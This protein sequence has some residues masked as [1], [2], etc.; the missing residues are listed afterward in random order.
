MTSDDV[1]GTTASTRSYYSL[2]V[3]LTWLA[4]CFTLC[5]LFSVI[6]FVSLLNKNILP[7]ELGP[8]T[9]PY[10][11]VPRHYDVQLQFNTEYNQ[12][13]T[14]FH[15][16][17]ALLFSSRHV[18]QRLFI[19]RG[20]YLRITDFSLIAVDQSNEKRSIKK[21]TYNAA[22]EIQTF[23]LS[24]DTA[25]DELYLF[26]MKFTGKMTVE[27][28]PKEFTYTSNNGEQRYGVWFATLQRNS[29]GLRYLFPCMD[30]NEFPAE[31]NITI[32]RKVSLR[33][34]SNFIAKRTLQSDANFMI[35]YFPPIT[36]LS[37]YQFALVLCD[38]QYRRENHN[39]TT[40]SVYS[41]Y[42][43]LQNVSFRRILQ[44]MNPTS[45]IIG[46]NDAITIPDVQT[47]YRPGI[48]LI[49]E[50]EFASESKELSITS[51]PNIENK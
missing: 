20:K 31:Y 2:R 40:I 33:A 28:G 38:F 4:I 36:V 25:I 8:Q 10:T 49:N 21:G 27:H 7:E 22:S 12:S 30:S 6:A 16:Q 48:S 18:S 9:I 14:S 11:N 5:L 1:Q 41:Q 32:T 44:F 45:N 15:G 50:K 17:V 35:D 23:V 51:K 29:K 24:F 26:T 46:K 19:H 3:L 42:D 47:V 13:N 43:M 37:P 34:L 39:G